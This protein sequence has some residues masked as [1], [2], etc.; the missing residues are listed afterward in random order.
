MKTFSAM[1]NRL[2]KH[3]YSALV[4]VC[5][6]MASMIFVASDANGQL[7]DE[8]IRELVS[9]MTLAEKVGQ[10]TQLTIQPLSEVKGFPGTAFKVDSRLL[11]EAIVDRHVGSLLNVYDMAMTTAEWEKLIN[12]IQ[13]LAIN[14]TKHGIPV[15]YG[16]DA[17]HGNNYHVEATLF[18][19]NLGLAATW[20]TE[21]VGAVSQQ[22]AEE[23]R[24]IGI[25][26]N[27]APVLD[28][29][30]QPL[31]SRFFETFGEDVHM[32]TV[33]GRAS[34]MSQQHASPDGFATVA[35]TGKHFLGYSLPLSGKD[36]TP[37][38]IPERMLREYILPPFKDAIDNGLL[39]MMVNS[40]E[41]NGEPVHASHRILTE[42]LKEELGFKGIIVTDWEDIAKLHASHRV[43]DSFKEAV[44]QVVVAGVDMAMVP[45]DYTFTD[46][47]IELVQEGVIP[48]SRIDES[49]ERILWVKSK[50]GLFADARPKPSEAVWTNGKALSLEAAQESI[51]LL[52]NENGILP[53]TGSEAVLLGGPGADSKTFIHGS[54][55]YTWQGLE[56]DAYPESIATFKEKM[57]DGFSSVAYVPWDEHQDPDKVRAMS[58][59]AEV[60][61]LALG[62]VPSVEKP[63]DIESLELASDQIELA[64]T[65][66]ESGAKLVVVLFQNRPRIIRQI[67][68]LAD[69][70]V[71]A[72]EPGPEGA[73]AV[74]EVLKGT[75]NPSGHLPFTYPRFSGSLVPYDYKWSEKADVLFG[76]DAINPQYP[77]GW[78]LSYTRFEYTN[79]TVDSK[80][81]S[82]TGKLTV[83]VDVAN[84]GDRDGMDVVQ[85]YSRDEYASITPSNRRLR[86]FLK[87]SLKA[88]E[89]STQ[90]FE[91]SKADLSFIG[92]DNTSVFESGDFTI[93][94]DDQS[95]LVSLR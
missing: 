52:K 81:F 33:L 72:Y 57:E 46:A 76:Q 3:I 78:G 66:A 91:L 58:H 18:P 1:S 79:L 15:I 71:L 65:V 80:A 21:L 10:M 32:A 59:R 38:W 63:G 4:V 61:V 83:S 2:T 26:W 45:Y 73:Q 22:T 67:E 53:L 47:L 60:V 29:G 8:A 5:Y 86:A 89:K 62:E 64:R 14:E 48:E 56:R 70:I 54:W 27:F 51:T 11:R 36:R 6:L 20:N 13:D 43:A 30:R 50:V 39:T 84:T 69:A 16:I 17:V 31:W 37:A 23:T 41:I 44:R 77:F 75:V 68:P 85:L 7:S 19:Q 92:R 12:E 93:M 82:A 74:V 35:A 9:E 88:G 49:V 87:V 34:I 28:V 42:L 95:T 90:R 24:S 25:P 94:V 55:S 40:G